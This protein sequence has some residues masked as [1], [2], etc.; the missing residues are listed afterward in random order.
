MQINAEKQTKDLITGEAQNIHDVM[1]ATEESRLAL[2]LTV[3]V[4][5]KLT[6][7]Y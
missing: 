2:E 1:L 5:S 6:D 7:S 4:L 3:Q